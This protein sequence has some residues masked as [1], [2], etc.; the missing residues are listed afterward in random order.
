MFSHHRYCGYPTREQNIFG[1]PKVVVDQHMD[2]VVPSGKSIWQQHREWQLETSRGFMQPPAFGPPP[3]PPP[4]ITM[5]P[6]QSAPWTAADDSALI[7]AKGQ[8]LGWNEIHQRFFPNKSGNSC[9]KR[10]ER[11]MFKLRS[12][13]WS[14]GRIQNVMNAY[15]TRG[16]REHF[17]RGIADPF[18]ENWQDAEKVV[19]V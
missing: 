11:L 12:C 13:E 1:M 7:D 4:P 2:H 17:W 9:R 14:D 6:G 15:N 8:G 18:G 5:H 16:V 19:R 10:H 3:P